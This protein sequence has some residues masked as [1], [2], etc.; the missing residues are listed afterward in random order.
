M[1]EFAVVLLGGIIV[2][3]VEDI[4]DPD[5]VKERFEG[6]LQRALHAQRFV[7]L[8]YILSFIVVGE[9]TSLQCK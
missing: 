6:H 7:F 3:S 9:L 8:A 4:P 2:I 1:H 5:V